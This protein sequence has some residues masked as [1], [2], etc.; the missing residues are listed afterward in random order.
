MCM[1]SSVHWSQPA[2]HPP[3]SR[4]HCG[5]RFCMGGAAGCHSIVGQ[6]R[7]TLSWAPLT[8]ASLLPPTDLYGRAPARDG[9]E[10]VRHHRQ[11]AEMISTPVQDWSPAFRATG[12]HTQRQQPKCPLC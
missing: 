11:M 2:V 1:P 12:S 7:H 4:A 9:P 5:S 6:T 3:K 10:K 8:L